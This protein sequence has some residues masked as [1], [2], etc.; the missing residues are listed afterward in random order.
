MMVLRKFGG[1]LL[2]LVGAVGVVSC[3]VALYHTGST[4]K[5]L[6]HFVDEV[7]DTTEDAL[8]SIRHRLVQI[9]IL[10]DQVRADL[11]TVVSSA[12]AL[13]TAGKGG[14]TPTE[15]IAFALDHEVME[16]LTNARQ[17]VDSAE[18]TA[19]SLSRLLTLLDAENPDSG[20][21]PGRDDSFMTRLK[22]ASGTLSRLP[23]MLDRARQAA[24]ELQLHPDSKVA[25]GALTRELG[26]MDKGVAEVQALAR[27]FE[28]TIQDVSDNCRYYRQMTFRY[29][30]LGSILIPLLL[31]W[32]G[33]GQAALIILG[34]A[35]L[36]E[37]ETM[38]KKGLSLISVVFF[39]LLTFPAFA[40]GKRGAKDFDLT[41]F[42]DTA[43]D[44]RISV[45]IKAKRAHLHFGK[46]HPGPVHIPEI[47]ITIP[48]HP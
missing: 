3:G 10:L 32:L 14:D 42:E 9:D 25:L 23:G 29:M 13:V 7:S 24:Q 21:D 39:V 45:R 34:G 20:K 27:E 41:V 17:L 12:E 44:G 48:P 1:I 18:D 19:S 2:M 46:C 33:A 35:F 28:R 47:H 15:H 5:Q 16:K 31:V 43:R 11:K 6:G 36:R 4:T 38:K 30:G 22:G 37:E 40:G 26:K 8:T